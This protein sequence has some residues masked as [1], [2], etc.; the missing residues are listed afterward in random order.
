MAHGLEELSRLSKDERF[1]T[2][3]AGERIAIEVSFDDATKI[4]GM[5]DR[6]F[7]RHHEAVSEDGRVFVRRRR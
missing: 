4:A 5:L 2:M 3:E 7:A 1:A 6:R